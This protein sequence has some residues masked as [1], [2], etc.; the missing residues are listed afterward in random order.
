MQSAS[1]GAFSKPRRDTLIVVAGTIIALLTAAV[2]GNACV[3]VMKQH[4]YDYH[5]ASFGEFG[6][7]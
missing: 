6:M 4:G 3:K 1:L 2:L 7:L 5:T